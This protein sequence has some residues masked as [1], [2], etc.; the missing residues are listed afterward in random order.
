VGVLPHPDHRPVAGGLLCLEGAP[1]F[2]TSAADWTT[3]ENKAKPKKNDERT[4][5]GMKWWNRCWGNCSCGCAVVLI[6]DEW[7]MEVDGGGASGLTTP[8]IS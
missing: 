2:G 4:V 8:G 3:N 7:G 1:Q 5:N 6:M